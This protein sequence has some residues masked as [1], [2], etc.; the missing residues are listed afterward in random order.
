MP[1]VFN[2]HYEDTGLWASEATVSAQIGDTILYTQNQA[3]YGTDASVQ[4][5]VINADGSEIQHMSLRMSSD[6]YANTTPDKFSDLYANDGVIQALSKGDAL[7]PGSLEYVQKRDMLRN[8][9]F[10]DPGE[11]LKAHDS[12]LPEGSTPYEEQLD[13]WRHA[14][15]IASGGGSSIK[16][17]RTQLSEWD[18]SMELRDIVNNGKESLRGSVTDGSAAVFNAASNYMGLQGLDA[19]DYRD[20]LV[21]DAN[22]YR[23]DMPEN[24]WLLKTMFNKQVIA[25]QAAQLNAAKASGFEERYGYDPYRDYHKTDAGPAMYQRPWQADGMASGAGEYAPSQSYEYQPIWASLYLDTSKSL[26]TAS[27]AYELQAQMDTINGYEDRTESQKAY[28]RQKQITRYWIEQIES[29]GGSQAFLDETFGGGDTFWGP[30]RHDTG[31][32]KARLNNAAYDFARISLDAKAD[33]DPWENTYLMTRHTNLD[34]Q[35]GWAMPWQ[36]AG[37]TALPERVH[38]SAAAVLHQQPGA[39]A[40]HGGGVDGLLDRATRALQPQH[41]PRRHFGEDW[42]RRHLGDS[43]KR[44]R[45]ARRKRCA[46]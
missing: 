41:A 31:S 39:D 2:T 15:Q 3:T 45:R 38:R 18:G 44:R 42:A 34:N 6:E 25:L 7:L 35:V 1:A 13:D 12:V 14:L 32:T 11:E 36:N 30:G 8:W 10:A 19:V 23:H 28:L 37:E 27:T 46:C 33:D 5:I 24:D 43:A 20:K 4:P 26:D 16:Q 22:Y 29:R 40:R 17:L 21:T 9:Y